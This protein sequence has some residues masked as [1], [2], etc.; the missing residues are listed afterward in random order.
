MSES[1]HTQ[2]KTAIAYYRISKTDGKTDR[3]VQDV[4]AECKKR[5]LKIVK[6]FREKRSG[7]QRNRP[8]VKEMFDYLENNHVD[9]CVISELSRY[10]RTNEV[11][12]LT[13][14]LKEL[15]VCLITLKE[16]ICT[17][18]DDPKEDARAQFIIN[19][20]AGMNTYELENIRYRVKSGRDYAV[21]N[22]GSWT[23]GKKYNLGYKTIPSYKST[24]SKLVVNEKEK[25]YVELIFE[26][27]NDGWGAVK[28]CNFLNSQ[29]IPTR[30]GKNGWARQTIIRILT[31]KIYIGKRPY[32][33]DY[34]D[35]PELRIISDYTFNTAQQR[36]RERK[37][38]SKEFSK[39]RKYEYLFDNRILKCMVCGKHFYGEH[40]KNIYKCI[41]KKHSAGCN[42]QSISLSWL[43]E[44]VLTYI[45]EHQL[46]LLD[47]SS[48]NEQQLEGY[49]IDLVLQEEQQKKAKQRLLRIKEIYID[50]DYNEHQYYIKKKETQELLDKINDK[51]KVIE[52]QLQ[53]KKTINTFKN[54]YVIDGKT[55]PIESTITKE[56]LHRIITHINVDMREIEICLINGESF[57]LTAPTP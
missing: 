30:T 55:V 40:R 34:I 54:E 16:G 48:S 36:L 23:G 17:I 29:N 45:M 18:N 7:A 12:I 11:L 31:N 50:G 44:T 21:L 4:E 53:V 15:G 26:K 35:V 14:K 56:T 1:T 43:E 6:D 41:S 42:N 3:Q 51:M 20:W 46:E 2:M 5:K 33:D 19:I 38:N 22:Q 57:F 8:R 52:E 37:S 47:S 13:D 25:P 49:K 10:G 24:P 27:F 32:N 9:Y 39:L 28:I